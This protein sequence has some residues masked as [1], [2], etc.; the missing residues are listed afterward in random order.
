MQ[1]DE[2]IYYLMD[3]GVDDGAYKGSTWV[4]MS[5]KDDRPSV[6][7]GTS[8]FSK[9]F[10]QPGMSSGRRETRRFT[11]RMKSPGEL[12]NGRL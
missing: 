8:P 7:S 11:E 6:K 4:I 12:R 9:S 3:G 1:L 10:G 2:D 5:Y